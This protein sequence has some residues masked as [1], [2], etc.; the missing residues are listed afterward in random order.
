MINMTTNIQTFIDTLLLLPEI[1]T[2]NTTD[3]NQYC[4]TISLKLAIDKCEPIRLMTAEPRILADHKPRLV[5]T[6]DCSA[7]YDAVRDVL[8]AQAASLRVNYRIIAAPVIERTYTEIN[9]APHRVLEP[10]GSGIIE[11]C[12]NG[13]YFNHI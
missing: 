12:D 4:V 3:I 5:D 11:L 1:E 10:N 8:R 6:V 13:E 7:S 9:P 2:I